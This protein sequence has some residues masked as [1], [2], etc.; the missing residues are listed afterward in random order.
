MTENKQV[1]ELVDKF[2]RRVDYIRLSVTDRCDFRCVYCMTEDMTFLPRDQILSLEELY[3][4][5]KAFTEL[6]GCKGITEVKDKAQK[7]TLEVLQHRLNV[8]GVL[9]HETIDDQALPVVQIHRLLWRKP[10]ILQLFFD[11]YAAHSWPF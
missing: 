5:A 6:C 10:E 1:T 11:V 8:R 3:R 9:R 2:G 7:G 4:V